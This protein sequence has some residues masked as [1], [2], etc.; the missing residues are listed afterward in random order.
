MW[1]L[2]LS[3]C[4]L[5]MRILCFL[6]AYIIWLPRAEVFIPEKGLKGLLTQRYFL[7]SKVE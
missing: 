6:C 7:A 1:P 4:S 5:I 2:V 3:H